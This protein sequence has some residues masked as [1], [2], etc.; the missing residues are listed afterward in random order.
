MLVRIAL[1][2]KLHNSMKT[3]PALGPKG[4][5]VERVC[6]TPAPKSKILCGTVELLHDCCYVI[7]RV[8]MS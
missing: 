5:I 8:V 2:S 3:R 7:V 1:T 4:V 6:V